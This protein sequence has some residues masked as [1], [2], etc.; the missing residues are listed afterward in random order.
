M[1]AQAPD[2]GVE[3][4]FALDLLEISPQTLADVGANQGLIARK[5]EKWGHALEFFNYIF[6]HPDRDAGH[7]P[8]LTETCAEITAL[9][10]SLFP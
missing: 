6:R 9:H 1:S 5:A 8:I 7:R 2:E 3:L 4:W 10:S